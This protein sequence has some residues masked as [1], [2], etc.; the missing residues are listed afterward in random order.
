M[1]ILPVYTIK[2]VLT[3]VHGDRGLRRIIQFK[4][5]L[6]VLTEKLRKYYHVDHVSDFMYVHLHQNIAVSHTSYIVKHSF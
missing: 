6:Y 2:P 3:D 4:N 5:T 1:A